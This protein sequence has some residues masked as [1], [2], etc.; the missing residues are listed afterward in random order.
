MRLPRAFSYKPFF[1]HPTPS[2]FSTYWS[3]TPPPLRQPHK[4]PS[5][6]L[7]PHI[8]AFKTW[9]HP[10]TNELNTTYL[11]PLITSTNV[12]VEITIPGEDG[13]PA[14]LPFNTF[15]N[16]LTS[17]DDGPGIYLTQHPPPPSLVDDLPPPFSHLGFTVI[18]AYQRGKG[19][20]CVYTSSLWLSRATNETHTPLHRDPN[21][22]LFLQLSSSKKII[23]ISPEMGDT[24]FRH[25]HQKGKLSSTD[26]RGRIRDGLLMAKESGVFDRIFWCPEDVEDE[27]EEEVVNTLAS[28]EVYF[29]TV[30]RGEAVYIPRGWWHSVKSV[31]GDRGVVGSMNWWFR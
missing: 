9:F 6:L 22:N 17:N 27:I 5:S 3:T 23:T 1:T 26:P 29:T 8:P 15:L 12:P 28:S 21:D 31:V 4:F 18:P 16:Y 7:T 14:A 11:N 13:E 2:T 30:E 25:L 24:I 10:N 20:I 19:G